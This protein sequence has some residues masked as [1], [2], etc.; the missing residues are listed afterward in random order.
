MDVTV[1]RNVGHFFRRRG[2][3]KIVRGSFG[4]SGSAYISRDEMLVVEG[5]TKGVF[6][7]GDINSLIARTD[8]ER[9]FGAIGFL[10]GALVLATILGILF[11]VIGAVIGIILAV[12][13]SFYS[14][15]SNIVE[16]VFS[17]DRRVELD[18]TPRGVKKLIQYKDST[19]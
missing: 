8:K 18:C 15:K 13:G 1:K 4:N 16:I 11:G 10:I 5:A 3:M 12:A 7:R 19:S 9:K 14:Q 2:P 6:G 17:D